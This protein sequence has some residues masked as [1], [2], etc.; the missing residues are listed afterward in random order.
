MYQPLL[1]PSD[2]RCKQIY[3]NLFR[4]GLHLGRDFGSSPTSSEQLSSLVLDFCSARLVESF[5]PDYTLIKA[6]LSLILGKTD[7]TPNC[8]YCESHAAARTE[9]T[10]PAVSKLTLLDVR[11]SI[12]PPFPVQLLCI[13]PSHD[14]RQAI[15][16]LPFFF[17]RPRPQRHQREPLRAAMMSTVAYTLP[18]L[19][20]F[21][22]N[23]S[24]AA[25][26]LQRR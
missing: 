16:V 1:E 12:T 9:L 21:D 11:Q 8:H 23:L 5:V 22:V 4:D 26:P 6:P 2:S 20:F 19:Y 14:L 13:V 18:V 3:V 17:H 24:V 7:P 25:D 15:S 10:R